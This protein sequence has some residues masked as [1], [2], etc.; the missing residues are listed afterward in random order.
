MT[1][2]TT[3]PPAPTP[4]ATLAALREMEMALKESNR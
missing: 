1:K 3:P 4:A 2:P